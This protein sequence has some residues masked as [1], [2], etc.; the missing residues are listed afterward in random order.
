M[1]AITP[2]SAS[3]PTPSVFSEIKASPMLLVFGVLF[4]VMAMF[5]AAFGWTRGVNTIGQIGLAA[6]FGCLAISQAW[7]PDRMWR[8]RAVTKAGRVLERMILGIALAMCL[9]L[10]QVAGWS[11]IGQQFEAAEQKADSARLARGADIQLLKSRQQELTALAGQRSSA[12]VRG[13]IEALLATPLRNGKTVAIVSHQCSQP[14]MAPS[15]CRQVVQLK[16]ELPKAERAETLKAQI[17]HAGR[18]MANAAAGDSSSAPQGAGAMVLLAGLLNVP[19]LSV[20]KWFPVL[21]WATLDFLATFGFALARHGHDANHRVRLEWA[22][23]NVRGGH[24][25]DSGPGRPQTAPE[26]APAP[27]LSSEPQPAPAIQE[28]QPV[29]AAAV[30]GS[31]VIPFRAVATAESSDRVVR[32]VIIRRRKRAA[33]TAEARAATA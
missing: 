12:E 19:E 1:R 28:A 25:G 3:P 22:T 11:A 13:Q 23:N 9:A 18:Q 7:L 5:N 27:G 29:P 10:S 8:A 31:N 30:V 16:A 26:I 20:L 21:M 4:L 14:E 6:S 15:A 32:Q 2:G 24:G 17:A 33:W